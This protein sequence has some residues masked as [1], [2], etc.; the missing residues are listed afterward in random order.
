MAICLADII[1]RPFYNSYFNYILKIIIHFWEITPV[2]TNNSN[3]IGTYLYL[4]K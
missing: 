3:I 2:A 4:Y 1:T